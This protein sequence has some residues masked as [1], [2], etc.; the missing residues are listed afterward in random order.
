MSLKK[1][2]NKIHYNLVE[3]FDKVDIN[4]RSSLEFGNYIELVI[5]ES[6]KQVLAIL[7]KPDLENFKFNWNYRSNPLDSN[8]ILVERVSSIET[9]TEDIKDIFEKNR[10]DSD[11]IKNI[12]KL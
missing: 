5:T 6:N 4:E 2:I 8:S 9:F 11:Y 7:R 1:N 12:S 10:F 3:N